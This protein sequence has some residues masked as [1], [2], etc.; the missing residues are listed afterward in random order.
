MFSYCSSLSSLPDLTQWDTKNTVYMRQMF[1]NC[2]SLSSLYGIDEWSTNKISDQLG[3]FNN[4]FSILFKNF[5]DRNLPYE[6]DEDIKNA[7]IVNIKELKNIL[8]DLDYQSDD[9][10]DMIFL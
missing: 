10:D 4:C 9:D 8:N 6:N 3:M 1:D 5:V 7:N 2:I